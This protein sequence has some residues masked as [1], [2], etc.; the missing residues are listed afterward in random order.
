M[1]LFAPLGSCNGLFQVKRMVQEGMLK[2]TYTAAPIQMK[3]Q[4][5]YQLF[6]LGDSI[7]NTPNI[8]SIWFH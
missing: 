8:S 1:Q 6:C 4:Y 3:I 7:H 2:L 5:A